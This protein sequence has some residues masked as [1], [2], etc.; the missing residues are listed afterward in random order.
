[1][2]NKKWPEAWVK[3]LDGW[4][5]E[6]KSGERLVYPEQ[7]LRAL[8]DIGALKDPPEPRKW[9]LCVDC[10]KIYQYPMHPQQGMWCDN[11]DKNRHNMI[12][13]REALDD[14]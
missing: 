1:M 9:E 3:E 12:V 2:E 6:A 10:N 13:V 5:F 14:E 8:H 4:L 11:N 7:V